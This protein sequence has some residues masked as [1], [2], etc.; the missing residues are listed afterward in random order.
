[1]KRADVVIVG[2]GVIGLSI[3]Y[4]LRRE[5]LDI[6]V[7]D[8]G[9]LGAQASWAGAG[10]ISPGSEI[11]LSHPA[12]QLR[13][14]SARLHAEWSRALL[15]ETGI[16]N[17]YR[18]CGGVDVALNPEET[19]ALAASAGRWRDEGIAFE[20]LA[21]SDIRKVEP[22]LS[23]AIEVGLLPPRS[24]PDPQPPAPQGFDRGP[25][26]T[27]RPAPGR[28]GGRDVHGRWRSSS[29]SGHVR[30]ADRMRVGRRLGRRLDPGVAGR[31]GRP[32]RH[33]AR[34]RSNRPAAV[35]SAR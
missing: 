14:L 34:A 8:R 35:R 32:D 7:L 16:D 31:A 4:A 17:G 33:A 6:V 15:D 13:T 21:R 3:A 11:P 28:H 1:M 12:A 18:L 23:H 30:R 24:R 2:G 9:P 25:A 19:H 20:K 27:K 26:T 29:R 22:S 5:P 10:I